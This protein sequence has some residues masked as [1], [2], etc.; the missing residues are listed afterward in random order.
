MDRPSSFNTS[1][2]S[3][4]LIAA[5]AV[6][7]WIKRLHRKKIAAVALTIPFF[8]LTL[9]FIFYHKLHADIERTGTGF[10][11]LQR[12][13]IDMQN[14]VRENTPKDALFLVPYDMEMGGFRIRSERSIVM[15]YRDC[16]V[17]GFD[18][19][20]GKEWKMP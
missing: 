18:Y 20:A 19:Q 2:I 13:W 17:I 5:C 11:Q 15:S 14:Y 12:N 6:L 16:G 4:A 8:L 10:W 1:W 9:N 3:E 7:S